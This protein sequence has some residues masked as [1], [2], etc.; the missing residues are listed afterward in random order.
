MGGPSVNVALTA[1]KVEDLLQNC[2][3]GVA[4]VLWITSGFIQ[5]DSPILTE[6]LDL[7]LSLNAR[8]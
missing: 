6:R 7:H 2:L 4:D 3:T 5:Q 1:V 8:K